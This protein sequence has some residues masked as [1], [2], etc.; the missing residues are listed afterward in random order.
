[1]HE[2]FRPG[3]Y[4]DAVGRFYHTPGRVK[5][6]CAQEQSAILE[7]TE[8]CEPSFI[9]DLLIPFDPIPIPLVRATTPLT[10]CDPPSGKTTGQIVEVKDRATPVGTDSV[11]FLDLGEQ[12]GLYPG[13]F[14]TVYRRRNDS[15]TIR[16]LLGE[17]AVFW[18]KGHTCVAKVT[19]MVDSLRLGDFVELK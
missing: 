1:G 19:S 7:F 6:V 5:V 4:L 3:S 17:V 12:D 15:G 18:T 13:D 11:V 8:S 2:V 16:T 10:Q 14:L 9:G